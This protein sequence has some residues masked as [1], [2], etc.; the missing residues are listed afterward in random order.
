M[1]LDREVAVQLKAVVSAL[2]KIIAANED[3][4]AGTKSKRV[5]R[6][7]KELSAFRKLLCAERKRGVPVSVVAKRHQISRTYIYQ[8]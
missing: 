7:G 5:R 6:S 3:D 2:E 8:L 4:A 1:P